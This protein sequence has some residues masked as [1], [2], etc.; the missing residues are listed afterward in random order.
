VGALY[1]SLVAALAY[2]ISLPYRKPYPYPPSPYPQVLDY[3]HYRL[4]TIIV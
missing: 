3:T 4:I 1:V 2:R